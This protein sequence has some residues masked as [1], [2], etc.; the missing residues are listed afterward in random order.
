MRLPNK[1]SN[2]PIMSSP[3]QSNLVQK[4]QPAHAKKSHSAACKQLY[5]LRDAS[6]IVAVYFQPQ[7]TTVV[8]VDCP[9]IRL[10]RSSPPALNNVAEMS[11]S[12]F[13]W[14]KPSRHVALRQIQRYKQPHRRPNDG[15]AWLEMHFG[16]NWCERRGAQ[17]PTT[18][19]KGPARARP[20]GCRAYASCGR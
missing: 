17:W 4:H 14:L 2:N 16:A 13:R 12:G 20:P 10:G 1:P 5:L 6:Y 18:F 11:S 19:S 3:Q 7:T 15:T 8:P 9:M